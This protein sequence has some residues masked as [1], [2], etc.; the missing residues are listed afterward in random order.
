MLSSQASSAI[1][2]TAS[3]GGPDFLLR[4]APWDEVQSFFR[5]LRE[6]MLRLIQPAE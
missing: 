2:E 3:T 6:E 5:T 4:A 1:R